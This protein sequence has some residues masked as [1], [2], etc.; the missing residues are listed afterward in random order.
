MFHSYGGQPM[1]K[2]RFASNSA[3]RTVGCLKSASNTSVIAH[4]LL[5]SDIFFE[6]AGAPFPQQK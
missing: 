2:R 5:P 1:K 6:S 4:V 3:T